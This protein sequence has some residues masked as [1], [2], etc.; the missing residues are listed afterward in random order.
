MKR[1]AL[2][3]VALVL[4]L[5]GCSSSGHASSAKGSDLNDISPSTG[6]FAGIEF[7]QPQPRPSFTLTDTTGKTVNF[8]TATANTATLLYFG[9]TN[10]PDVCPE[11]MADVGLALKS[12]PVATQQKVDVV[13]VSTDVKHDTAP[14]ITKWLSNFS[15]DNHAHFIGLRGTQAQI[16]AAQASAHVVVAEDGGETHSAQLLLYGADNY[17]RVSYVPTSAGEQKQIAHDLPLVVGK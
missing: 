8:G 4:A 15:T 13:F 10:C 16:N 6:K 14:I 3:G 12:L 7:G 17:A 5:A 2:A 11:T 9:Y 1:L